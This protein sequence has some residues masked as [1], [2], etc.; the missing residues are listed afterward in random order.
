MPG[1]ERECLTQS[2]YEDYYSE[3]LRVLHYKYDAVGIPYRKENG[4]RACPIETLAAD[5]TTV[6]LLAFGSEVAKEIEQGKPVHIRA[7]SATAN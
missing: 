7:R 2:E 5:D 4:Q 6:F 1:H 3:A